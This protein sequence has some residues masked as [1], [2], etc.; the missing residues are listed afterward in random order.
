MI[1]SDPYQLFL[2]NIIFSVSTII[3][4]IK[5]SLYFVL[6]THLIEHHYKTFYFKLNFNISFFIA[7]FNYIS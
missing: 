5:H 1:N 3:W 6:L 4:I 2:L 7:K